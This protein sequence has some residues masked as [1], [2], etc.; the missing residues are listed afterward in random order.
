MTSVFRK[1]GSIPLVMTLRTLTYD[2]NSSS[3]Y[4]QPQG[5]AAAVYDRLLPLHEV[6]QRMTLERVA[7]LT[8]QA[9]A[10]AC[11]RCGQRTTLERV[12]SLITQAQAHAHAHARAHPLRKTKFVLFAV[13]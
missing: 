7:S 5:S 2:T 10:H 9:Q 1:G 11:L 3:R 4:T 13:E 6:G 8:T 12:A